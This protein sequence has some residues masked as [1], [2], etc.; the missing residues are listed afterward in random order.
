MDKL[1]RL[2]ALTGDANVCGEAFASQPSMF[3]SAKPQHLYEGTDSDDDEIVISRTK[4][5]SSSTNKDFNPSTSHSGLSVMLSGHR[6]PWTLICYTGRNTVS[7]AFP[8]YDLQ[9]GELA[10]DGESFCPFQ[11]VKRYPYA[12]IGNANRQRVSFNAISVETES[13]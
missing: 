12:Y 13:H 5:V 8:K 9:V 2:Q 7:S 6:L 1:N 11:T 10:A 3:A 4:V